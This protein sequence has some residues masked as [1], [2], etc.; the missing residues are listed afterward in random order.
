MNKKIFYIGITGNRDISINQKI[1]IK[2]QLLEILTKISKDY[3]NI[4]ILTPLADGVDRLITEVV[5]ENQ[6]FNAFDFLIPLPMDEEIYLDTF[7]K[8]LK[9]NSITSK[10]SIQDYNHLKN[11]I[12][13]FTNKE[14]II[15]NLPFD[16]RLYFSSNSDEQRNIRRNQYE[17][18]GEYLIDKSD[19]LIAVYDENRE[20]K[21]GG[22]LEIVNKFNLL[23]KHR[24]KLFKIKL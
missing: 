16:R 2:F 18:L 24:K 10:E 1:F 12:Q 4:V 13:T 17:L 9:V 19:V 6:Q 8:G 20:V 21:K 23:K 3:E 15:L 22:S 5:L 14:D 7:A 11:Q